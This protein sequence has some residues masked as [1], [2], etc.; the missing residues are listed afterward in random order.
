MAVGPTNVGTPDVFRPAVQAQQ[1]ANEDD[2]RTND[3][4]P[5][6]GPVAADAPVGGAVEANPDTVVAS[7]N[8]ADEPAVTNP[9]SAQDDTQPANEEPSADGDAARL[10]SLIDIEV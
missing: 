10:G 7:V 2:R 4:G 8:E 6:A 9:Q 5:D 1:T 3:E